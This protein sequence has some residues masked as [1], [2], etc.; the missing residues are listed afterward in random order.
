MVQPYLNDEGVE[1]PGVTTIL[2]EINQERLNTWKVEQALRLVVN[3]ATKRGAIP[4]TIRQVKAEQENNAKLGSWLH[5]VAAAKLTGRDEI[6]NIEG[7]ISTCQILEG[8]LNS[9]LK[10]IGDF[11]VLEV[12]KQVFGTI[13]SPFQGKVIEYAGTFDALIQHL[14]NTILLDFKTSRRIYP[15]H[16]AHC[17]LYTS[18]SPRD[19][20]KSRMPSSA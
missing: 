3:I 20:Q 4:E 10:D 15:E 19:R 6:P 9:Y 17:L 14:D 18:P 11:Q 5:Q 8:N 12:E 13:R 7:Q 16:I 2:K 1:V